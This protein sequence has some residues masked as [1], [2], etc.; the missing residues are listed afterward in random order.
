MS[1]N[2]GLLASEPTAVTEIVRVIA[3]LATTFG[4]AVNASDQAALVA[5][6]GAAL[7]IGSIALAWFNRQ[8]VFAPKNVQEIANAA[9]FQPPGTVVDIGKPP[10]GAVD[11]VG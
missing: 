5:V 9:T 8:H 2:T 4:I 3:L 7:T 11:G 6:I 10:E 1:A